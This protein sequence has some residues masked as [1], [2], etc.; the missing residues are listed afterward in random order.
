M[1]DCLFSVHATS[2]HCGKGDGEN[3]IHLQNTGGKKHVLPIG[4]IHHKNLPPEHQQQWQHLLGHPEVAVVASTH[5][6]QR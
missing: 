5:H 2:R 3:V 4:C 1:H 6:L